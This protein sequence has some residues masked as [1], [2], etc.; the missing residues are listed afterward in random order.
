M[1]TRKSFK[2][3]ARE[4]KNNKHIFYELSV[5]S[6]GLIL[7]VYSP[8][9]FVWIALRTSVRYP[10]VS[11]IL[12]VLSCWNCLYWNIRY[13]IILSRR[14]IFLL[15]FNLCLYRISIC[16]WIHVIHVLCINSYKLYSRISAMSGVDTDRCI[17]SNEL[18]A[19]VDMWTF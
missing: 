6:G 16:H 1:L 12:L 13:I 7:I 14:I 9:M 11:V 8:A 5:L 2:Y 10:L 19:N 17:V 18:V 15:S 3:T 4:N